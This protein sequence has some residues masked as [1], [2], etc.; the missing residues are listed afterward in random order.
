[1]KDQSKASSGLNHVKCRKCKA[2]TQ[3]LVWLSSH[4]SKLRRAALHL[5][6]SVGPDRSVLWSVSWGEFS[7]VAGGGHGALCATLSSG[8]S[9]PLGPDPVEGTALIL[10]LLSQTG[11]QET[12]ESLQ[13]WAPVCCD[14]CDHRLCD[15]SRSCHPSPKKT[16]PCLVFP[17]QNPH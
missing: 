7:A 13:G 17:L 10:V 4:W 3:I 15:S 11:T 14:M 12:P 16:D 8:L 9:H 5:L 1:M 2:D 6:W